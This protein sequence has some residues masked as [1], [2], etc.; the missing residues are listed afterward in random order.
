M[1]VTRLLHFESAANNG[2]YE[3]FGFDFGFILPVF[4]SKPYGQCLHPFL[5]Q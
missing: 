5:Q 4:L 2:F 3:L 1:L